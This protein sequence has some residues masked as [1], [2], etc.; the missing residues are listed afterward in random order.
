MSTLKSTF[1]SKSTFKS[2]QKST[3][4]STFGSS[5]ST[6]PVGTAENVENLYLFVVCWCTQRLSE[7]WGVWCERGTICHGISSHQARANLG[8]IKFPSN[9]SRSQIQLQA[10]IFIRREYFD[11]SVI[12]SIHLANWR[13]EEH[14]KN[15]NCKY[16]AHIYSPHLCFGLGFT[17][18][19]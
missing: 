4:M 9:F 17:P 8:V 16:C 13:L 15:E 3:L 6:S 14:W 10:N 18:G 12:M 1:P 7:I 2:A 11:T 5:D 19:L